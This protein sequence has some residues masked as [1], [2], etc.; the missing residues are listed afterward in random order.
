MIMQYNVQFT[1]ERYHNSNA[2]FSTMII[3]LQ[4]VL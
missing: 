4:T 2:W 1:L 3:L